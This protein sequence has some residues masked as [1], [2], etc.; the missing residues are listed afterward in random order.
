[1]L[2]FFSLLLIAV[3]GYVAVDN[4][5]LKDVSIDNEALYA[6]TIFKEAR[7]PFDAIEEVKLRG[8][9]KRSLMVVCV[10]LRSPGGFGREILFEPEWR[11]SPPEP[12]EE[13]E[14]LIIAK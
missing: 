1:M 11:L 13:L 7:I 8:R 3:V 9:S 2:L 6:S 4:S 12:W 10:K 5:R 14:D